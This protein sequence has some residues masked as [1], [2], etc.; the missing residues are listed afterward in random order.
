MQIDGLSNAK[1]LG[2][3]TLRCR[4][5]QKLLYCDRQASNLWHCAPSVLRKALMGLD[6]FRRSIY[7]LRIEHWPRHQ[8]KRKESVMIGVTAATW[9]KHKH[10]DRRHCVLY[11]GKV[12]RCQLHPLSTSISLPSPKR[13]ACV[14]IRRHPQKWWTMK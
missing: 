2:L 3:T 8:S 4:Y 14:L 13:W 1:D 12:L 6:V 9:L 11:S 10:L 7:P 5:R